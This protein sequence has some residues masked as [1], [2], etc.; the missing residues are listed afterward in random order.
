MMTD[1]LLGLQQVPSVRIR[2][3]GSATCESTDPQE[4]LHRPQHSYSK[5][6]INYLYTF[7]FYSEPEVKPKAS[8]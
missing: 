1:W 5:W 7:E 2:Q 6:C 8:R 3:T 4:G